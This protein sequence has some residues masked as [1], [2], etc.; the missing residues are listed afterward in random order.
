ML[1]L[2][3]QHQIIKN[4]HQIFLFF[5]LRSEAKIYF[6]IIKLILASVLCA[7]LALSYDF[8]QKDSIFERYQSYD[9]WDSSTF[10]RD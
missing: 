2:P 10:S 6:I 1:P 9:I 7:C 4:I 5:S 8:C 3:N